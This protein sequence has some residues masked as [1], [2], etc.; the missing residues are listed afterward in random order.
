MRAAQA[1]HRRDAHACDDANLPL[2]ELAG[3]G[4][5]YGEIG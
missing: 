3:L 2:R 5:D 4:V 1:A